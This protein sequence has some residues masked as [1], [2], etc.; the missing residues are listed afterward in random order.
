MLGWMRHRVEN[1]LPTYPGNHHLLHYHADGGP[2]LIDQ[3]LKT[4]LLKT[5]GTNVTWSSTDT[6]ELNAISKRKFRTLGE[7][8][9]AMLVDSG[10]PKSFWWDA[11]V[12]AYEITLK[13]PTRTCRSWMSTMECVHGGKTPNL[14]RLRRWVCKAYA[15]VSRADRCKDWEDNAMVGYFL[16]DS[17]TKAGCRIL[18]GDTTVTSV[19]VLFDESIPERYQ[20]EDKTPVHIADLQ[21]MTEEFFMTTAIKACQSLKR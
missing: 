8:T 5:F 14:S 3:R 1:I 12:A 13:M 9:L 17:K 20:I 4:Y 10:L 11:Y 2:E 15:L 21:S 18:L 6:L 19:Q 16:G 7:M